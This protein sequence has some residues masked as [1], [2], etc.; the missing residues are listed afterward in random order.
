M[1]TE[2]WNEEVSNADLLHVQKL[3]EKIRGQQEL[4]VTGSIVIWSWLQKRIQPL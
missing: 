3:L 4:G 2:C 1:P